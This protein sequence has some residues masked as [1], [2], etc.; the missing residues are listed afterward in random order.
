MNEQK[1][2]YSIGSVSHG[3][4]RKEDLIPCFLDIAKEL[5]GE[6]ELLLTIQER[7]DFNEDE[8]NSYNYY[9]SDESDYDLDELFDALQEFAPPYFYFGS[10]PGDGADYGYWLIDDV[11]QQVKDDGG[12]TTDD[13]GKT[14]EEIKAEYSGG[15]FEILDVNDHGNISLYTYD[16]DKNETTEVWAIV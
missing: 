7:I 9:K 14:I 16:L 8:D 13:I 5:G 15:T 4:M 2:N 10:H 1:H 3:T 11:V 12:Y 6:T